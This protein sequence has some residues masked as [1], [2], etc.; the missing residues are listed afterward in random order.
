MKMPPAVATSL[1]ATLR[2]LGV[3]DGLVDLNLR[4]MATLGTLAEIG[5]PYGRGHQERT[6]RWAAAVAEE[7][8]LASD[9]VRSTRMAGLVHDL[10]NVGTSKRILNKPGKLTEG[11]FA[12]IKEHAPL[13]SI[14]IM[15]E[16][17]TLQRIV[18]V[19]RHHHEHFDGKGYP[20]GLSGEEIPIEARILAVVDAFDAMTH[21]RSYRRALTKENTIAELKRCAG[22]QFDPT[23]VEALLT[24]L[25]RRGDDFEAA[26]PVSET[27]EPA[28]ATTAAPETAKTPT[29]SS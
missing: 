27:V 20:D 28:A 24:L 26:Q 6:S 10:G 9:R 4:T 12:K 2:R 8:G 7:M 1:V 21:D 11:E 16:I 3:P 13:A 25:A 18:P 5:D 29:T 14:M 19:V 15:S 23:V 22:T 17:E